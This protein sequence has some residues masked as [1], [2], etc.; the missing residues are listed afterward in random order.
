MYSVSKQ[1]HDTSRQDDAQDSLET[2]TIVPAATNEDAR[3]TKNPES[4]TAFH[5]IDLR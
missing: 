2:H 1:Q 3:L 5:R 4:Q